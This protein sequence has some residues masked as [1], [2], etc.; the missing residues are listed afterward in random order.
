MIIPFKVTIPDHEQ[1]KEL[2]KKIIKEELSGIFNWV[3]EGLKR[4]LSQKNFT[5]STEIFKQLEEFKKFSDTV[6]L[7][8]EDSG[9]IKSAH[10]YT[11][12][13]DLYSAYRIY[14]VDD[15]F[16]PVNKINFRKRL[17]GFGVVVEKKNTGL[18]AFVEQKHENF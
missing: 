2:A 11:S 15:G 17:E 12:I 14:C 5:S 9:Y 1:D 16:K 8:L 13:R 3:L 7:F 4:L 18:S 10:N 6:Q